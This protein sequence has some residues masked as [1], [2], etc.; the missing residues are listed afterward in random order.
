MYISHNLLPV[1]PSQ[2]ETRRKVPHT[3]T[4]HMYTTCSHREKSYCLSLSLDPRGNEIT[5]NVM[6]GLS[7][8]GNNYTRS[9]TNYKNSVANQRMILQCHHSSLTVTVAVRDVWCYI[10][11]PQIKHSCIYKIIVLLD[12][13]VRQHDSR[14]Y[15][16]IVY[17]HNERCMY[18]YSQLYMLA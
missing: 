16:Y 7:M 6:V 10:L 12:K 14:Q 2:S 15:M 13:K 17:V 1:L 3:V 4:M 8:Y 18:I 11:S 5:C 9:V